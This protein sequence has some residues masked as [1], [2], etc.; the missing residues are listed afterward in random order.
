MDFNYFFDSLYIYCTYQKY[1]SIWRFIFS[2]FTS[3]GNMLGGRYYPM[4]VF[5]PVYPI[6]NH[7]EIIC[8]CWFCFYFFIFCFCF[9]VF[10]FLISTSV[11][12]TIFAGLM[13]CTLLGFNSKYCKFPYKYY[14]DPD[15]KPNMFVFVCLFFVFFSF[16]HL[17]VCCCCFFFHFFL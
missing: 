9:F 12:V 10:C 8:C 15:T 3:S 11:T 4:G 5:T 16:F 14:T 13:F 2:N 17:F 6:L 1:N 7:T